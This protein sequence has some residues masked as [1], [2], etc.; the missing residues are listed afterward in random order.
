MIYS[1]DKK[2]L[3]AY[4]EVSQKSNFD[5]SLKTGQDSREGFMDEFDKEKI[6][7]DTT[8]ID[9]YKMIIRQLK[10]VESK[11]SVDPKVTQE[12]IKNV[13]DMSMAYFELGME[14]APK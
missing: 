3:E 7:P 13:N 11:Y 2:L 4:E 14:K 6:G 10:E 12:I 1:S 5:P 9:F 8:A